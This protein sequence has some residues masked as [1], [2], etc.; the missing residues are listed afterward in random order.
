MKIPYMHLL[1]LSSYRIALCMV[2]V[3]LG[4]EDYIYK[5]PTVNNVRTKNTHHCWMYT[6]FLKVSTVSGWSIG[7]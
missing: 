7:L 4:F 5:V 1:V 3:Y 2:M 6:A